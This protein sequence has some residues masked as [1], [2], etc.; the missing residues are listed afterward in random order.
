MGATGAELYSSA[1]HS[2]CTWAGLV[3]EWVQRDPSQEC[4]NGTRPVALFLPQS[5]TA[6]AQS[7][8]GG[9]REGQ[10]TEL[11]KGRA[12]TALDP[13]LCPVSTGSDPLTV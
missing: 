12:V 11:G 7:L 9:E 3:Q 2:N 5:L 4:L 13:N 10:W 1:W 6:W 8:T